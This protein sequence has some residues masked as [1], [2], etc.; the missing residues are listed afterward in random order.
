MGIEVISWDTVIGKKVK[1]SDEKDLGKVHTI[2][3]DLIQTKEGLV[4]KNYY[5]IPK[6]YVQGYDGEHVWVSLTEDEVK[7]KFERD[8]APTD[9]KG[10]LP[11]GYDEKRAC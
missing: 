4:S 6:Y 2:T 9:L 5:F 7:V 10:F 8:N 3:K 1:S 11:E